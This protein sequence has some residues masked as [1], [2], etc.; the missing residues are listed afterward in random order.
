MGGLPKEAM[1]KN[2]NE[3]SVQ[4]IYRHKTELRVTLT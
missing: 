3:S 1:K 4:Q 2:M